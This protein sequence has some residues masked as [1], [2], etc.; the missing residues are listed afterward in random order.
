MLAESSKGYVRIDLHADGALGVT[1]L[2]LRDGKNAEPI[3]RHCLAE[4]PPG[5]RRVRRPRES[6]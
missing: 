6:P 2:A 5:P 4:Q 1:V 3:F